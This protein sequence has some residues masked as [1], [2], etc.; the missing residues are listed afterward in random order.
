MKM[1]F[2][3]LDSSRVARKASA[4]LELH[5]QVPAAEGDKLAEA[6]TPSLESTSDDNKKRTRKSSRASQNAEFAIVAAALHAATTPAL[7]RRVN[8]KASVAVVIEVPD[9]DWVKSVEAYLQETSP[10]GLVTFVRSGSNKPRDKNTEGNDAVAGNL[11]KGRRV[12]GIATNPDTSLPAVLLTAAELRIRIS[13]PDGAVVQ[14]AM[15]RCLRGRLPERVDDEIVAG[16]GIN[17]YIS[18]MRYG[19]TPLQALERLRIA[20]ARHNAVQQTANVPLL[21]DAVEYGAAREWGLA[22]ARD[23][24]DYRAG[25]LSWSACDRGAVFYSGPGCGKSVLAASIAQAC[26]VP[27]IRSSMSEFFADSAGDLG[28]VIKS[29]RATFARAAAAAPCILFLDEID[30]VP[31]R[32]TLSPRGADWWLPVIN[33]LLLLLDAAVGGQREGVVVLGATNRIE[34]V[35]EALLRPGRLERRIEIGRPDLAGTQNI[36]RFHLGADLKDV[37]IIDVAQLLEGSTAAEIMETVRGARRIARHAN[38]DL[39]VDDLRRQYMGAADEPP[40]RLRRMAIHE[41]AHAVAA[42]AIGTGELQRVVLRADG[43]SGGRT[44]IDYPAHDLLTLA[45][46]EDRVTAILSAGVAERLILGTISAGPGGTDNSDLGVATAMIAILHA[47]TSMVGNLFHRCSGEK[48]L[49]TARADP[50]LRR[51]IEHHLRKIEMR[52][53]KL[54]ERHRESVIA[55]ADELAIK[56]YLTGAEVT[57][58][59]ERIT[60]AKGDT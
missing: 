4:R 41:A 39:T 12:I 23:I 15:R 27:L 11:S 5:V 43:V 2:G 58:I 57:A 21:Q 10:K 28:A 56:R 54:V 33:D 19:S 50:L 7:R 36:L 31:N 40:L 48:A 24:A 6:D 60:S 59:V 13:P 47:S 14:D 29:Q 25:R 53:E 30:A 22:L 3:R 51:A 9:A 49:A 32:R 35:D 38:R 18:A 45:G 16:L 42:V 8:G 17:D 37:D 34:A 26:G 1:T 55:V 46:A 52:A 44:I 20:K